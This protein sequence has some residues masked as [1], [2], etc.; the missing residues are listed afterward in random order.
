MNKKDFKDFNLLEVGNN[1]GLSG[2][3]LDGKGGPVTLMFPG[4]S[5][6][7]VSSSEVIETDVQQFKDMVRQMD[8]QEVELIDNDKNKKT[9]VRKT[10]RQLDT[11]ISWKV[12]G[13]DKYTCRYCG[14]KGE[15][16]VPMSYDH[17]M[18]WENGGPNTMDN[19]VCACKKC[20]K[21]RG[22]TDY[23]EWLE[24]PYYKK[25]SSGLSQ[26]TKKLNEALVSVYKTF[27]KR[28]SKRSR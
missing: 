15:D 4:I 13:R 26:G 28:V 5:S 9:I 27:T 25:V 3:V 23:A 12:F 22:N 1:L 6:D 10:Q 20:N 19:G 2:I 14:R 17:I 8:I 7:N 11:K 21:T 18:L 24:S 16:G